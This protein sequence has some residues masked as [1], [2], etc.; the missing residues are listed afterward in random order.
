MDRWALVYWQG[1]VTHLYQLSEHD[2]IR[3]DADYFIGTWEECEAKI[4]ELG[5]E[6]P[7]DPEEDENV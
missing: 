4:E 6:L 2:E 1:K 7:E 5:L 3:T